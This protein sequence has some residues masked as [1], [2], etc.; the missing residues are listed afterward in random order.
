MFTTIKN[1]VL[2]TLISLSLGA[3]LLVSAVCLYGVFNMRAWINQGVNELGAGVE[4]QSAD[5]LGGAIEHE[6]RTA[7]TDKAALISEKLA[8]IELQTL[9]A[10]SAAEYI[11][12]HPDEFKPRPIDYLRPGQENTAIPHI[13]TA[14]GADPAALRAEIYLAANV[15]DALR[16]ILAADIGLNAS[17][18][19]VESGY[20]IS[21]DK[22]AA[23]PEN[24]NYDPTTRPWYAGAKEKNGIFWSDVFLDSSGRGLSLSC[25]MPFYTEEN[26]VRTLKGVAG[27]GAELNNISAIIDETNIDGAGYA[28][29]LNHRGEIIMSPKLTE[30][31]TDAQGNLV[32][33]KYGDNDGDGDN[34]DGGGGSPAQS[35][36]AKMTSGQTGVGSM[37]L[38]GEDVY[39]GYAPLSVNNWSVGIVVAQSDVLAPVEDMRRRLN[40]L[41]ASTEL[42][43]NENITFT[44]VSLLAVSLLAVLAAVGLSLRFA[45]R[46]TGPIVKLNRGVQEV[47]EGNLDAVIAVEGKDEIGQLARAFNAMTQRLKEHIRNLSAAT[48]EKERIAAELNIA[49]KIQSG[50]L[51]VMPPFPDRTDFDLYALMHPAK[52]VGGDFYDFFLADET[53]LGV[54]VAD[55]AGKSVPAA[56]FMIVAKTLLRN[57]MRLEADLE[58]AFFAV[59]NQLADR[60]EE[61]MFVTAFAGLLDTDTGW[62]TY[63]NA[64]HVPPALRRGSQPFVRLQTEPGFVLGGLENIAY[65]AARVRLQPGDLIFMYTDGVSEASNRAGDLFSEQRVLADLNAC[66]PPGAGA[67]SCVEK[68]RAALTDFT[69]GAEQTDDVTMLVLRYLGGPAAQKLTV[70]A[71]AARLPEV[72]AFL[73]DRMTA[74]GFPAPEAE[75]LQLAVEEIFVNITRYAY[76]EGGGSVELTCVCAADRVAVT[77][78]DGGLPYNPLARPDPDVNLPAEKR[79]IGGLGVYMAKTL[80]DDIHYATKDGKNVLTLGKNAGGTGAGGTDSGAGGTD[81]LATDQGNRT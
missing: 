2:F 52:E 30:Y 27:S 25:S 71:D 73:S 31:E 55:V 32:L 59:N 67:T 47:S 18:I 8:A 5:E 74:A 44:S 77:V 45:G 76:P 11:F 46:I 41:Y 36:T 19:G 81:P 29:L 37:R 39:V 51:P 15:Q 10:A 63:V 38:N 6:L 9:R 62:F 28:F 23:G 4:S 21:V 3:L 12:A 58:K 35:L 78:E 7:I 56:M 40:A 65:T 80:L 60:N 34:G 43:M 14:P 64:G 26:G 66:V 72:A 61:A 68:I 17:Y 16:G 24:D 54:V 48:A 57:Q 33:E 75:Y 22:N 20:F 69:E 70:A 49:A 79:G 53:H 50:M 1:R 13:R 42:A